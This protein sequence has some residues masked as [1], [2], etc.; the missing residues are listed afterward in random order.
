MLK[1]QES[2]QIHI[3]MWGPSCTNW[4]P[5]MFTYNN[6]LQ[7]W[8]WLFAHRCFLPLP[9]ATWCVFLWKN[10][11]TSRVLTW[12]LVL[13]RTMDDVLLASK[14]GS[15]RL[16]AASIPLLYFYRTVAGLTFIKSG[17]RGQ[18]E[19]LIHS[20]LSRLTMLC[21]TLVTQ[22]LTTIKAAVWRIC[23]TVW[24]MAGAPQYFYSF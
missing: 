8:V 23:L 9:A 24:Y 14:T 20:L 13:T 2:Y 4:S 19:E 18:M 15:R 6:W 10:I 22:S 7:L 3:T 1:L 12:E 16:S 11:K 17:D 21:W 5:C